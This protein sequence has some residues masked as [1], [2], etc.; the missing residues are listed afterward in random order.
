MPAAWLAA[1]RLGGAAARGRGRHGHPQGSGVPTRHDRPDPVHGRPRSLAVVTDARVRRPQFVPPGRSSILVYASSLWTVPTAAI[2]P[3]R[4]AHDLPRRSDSRSDARRSCSC[5][6]RGPLDWSDGRTVAGS[7]C[8][9][10]R[11]IAERGD[12]R[13]HPRASLG[14][15]AVRADA[16][17]ARR[18]S[19]AD[20][21]PRL[22]APW[23]ARRPLDAVRPSRSS[24]T[25]S[26]LGSAFAVLGLHHA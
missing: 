16:V 17:A 26:L 14:G 25:R 11:S 15:H 8:C 22:R 6:S 23:A 24:P 10:S 20:H 21:A 5:S 12:D 1:F 2:V 18:R 7:A 13:A 3:A 19:A 4:A 9:C